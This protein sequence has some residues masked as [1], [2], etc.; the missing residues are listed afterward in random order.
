MTITIY[1]NGEVFIPAKLIGYVGETEYR[2]I[3]FDQPIITG[4]SEYKFRIEYSDG[5][6]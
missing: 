4:A 2:S 3:T 6:I 5:L 1:Q